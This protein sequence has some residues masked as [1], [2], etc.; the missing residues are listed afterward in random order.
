[1]FTFLF[2]I[3]IPSSSDAIMCI[4][5]Q[6]DSYLE[7]YIATGFKKM[8]GTQREVEAKRKDGTCF[9]CTLGIAELSYDGNSEREFVGFIR[10]VTVQKSLLVAEAE[11]QASDSLLENVFP[12]HIAHRLKKDPGHIADHYDNTTILFADIVGFTDRATKMSPHDVVTMLNDL[13]SRFDLLVDHYDLNKVKTI[14]DCYMVTSIP[15][16]ELGELDGR[17][18]CSRVCQFALDLLLS[19]QEFNLAGPQHGQLELRIGIAIGQVVAGVVGTKRFLFDMWGDAVNV[20]AR[21]EQHGL[22]GQIQV[23][24]EVVNSVCTEFNFEGRGKQEVKG[25]GILETFLLKSAKKKFSPRRSSQY[26]RWKPIPTP[27]ATRSNSTKI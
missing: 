13:F 1:M 15:S 22:A 23:T 19:V 17:A 18:G 4:L 10:D 12:E 6:H 3:S 2:S 25:K 27:P 14:G 24:K 16:N 21:M 9:P 20:A 11:R 8:I 26:N 7:H 5:G